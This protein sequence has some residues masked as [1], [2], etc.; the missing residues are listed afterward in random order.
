MRI[1]SSFRNTTEARVTSPHDKTRRVPEYTVFPVAKFVL[2]S[3]DES[4]TMFSPCN[5]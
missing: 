2:V 1:G 4:S 5:A 3:F